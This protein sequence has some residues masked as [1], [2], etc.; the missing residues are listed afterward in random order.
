[1]NVEWITGP[2]RPIEYLWV[3][4]AHQSKPVI[5][6]KS[7][8]W[9]HMI[10]YR[11][12]LLPARWCEITPMSIICVCVRLLGNR[13]EQGEAKRNPTSCN[14]RYQKLLKIFAA[15]CFSALTSQIIWSSF[16][17][18][19]N[20]KIKK[21]TNS[22]GKDAVMWLNVNHDK[23]VISHKIMYYCIKFWA[24]VY[25]I[26]LLNAHFLQRV[27]IARIAERCTI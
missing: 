11:C 5:A 27:R 7:A 14:L 4:T 26:Y 3:F 13:L 20:G 9:W 16:I 8:Y 17:C 25:H 10:H 19:R 12:W 23:T 21:V 6:N 1:V 22:A 2:T 15:A 24:I 18:K